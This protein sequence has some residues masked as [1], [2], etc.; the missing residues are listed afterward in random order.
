MSTVNSVKATIVAALP[1]SGVM[2][3]VVGFIILVLG[4][5][6]LYYLYSYLFGMP[7]VQSTVIVG[8]S[9]PANQ[10]TASQLYSIPPPYEGGEYSVSFWSYITGWKDKL[11]QRKH[12]LEIRGSE[13]STLVVG[14]GVH[15]NNLVVRV[16]TKVPGDTAPPAPS[17]KPAVDPGLSVSQ[18]TNLSTENVK[19]LFAGGQMDQGL[20]ETYPLCDLPSIDLQ[21]WV[22]ISVILNGKTCDVYLDGKLARSC[23]LPSFYRVDPKGVS[24]KLLDF[25]GYDGF[26]S[27]VTFVQ[28]SLNPDEIYRMYMSGPT[29]SGSGSFLDM[30]ANLFNV[31]GSLT[32]KT[33]QVNVT[34]AK[35]TIQV[36]S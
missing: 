4:I 33:P 7:K 24:A 20:L 21:R 15:K 16:H 5:T 14:L 29:T 36:G 23:I 22:L 12:I 26:I 3:Y 19:Q 30:L 18:N 27:D 1:T 10:P 2:S 17:G 35:S 11:G 34:Y 6:A 9:I 25:G 13:F 31:S 28:R 8:S 32:L